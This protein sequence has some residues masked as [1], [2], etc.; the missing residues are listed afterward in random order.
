MSDVR[1]VDR[2]RDDVVGHAVVR[3]REQ[4]SGG[5]K[6]DRQEEV[7]QPLAPGEAPVRASSA[8]PHPGIAC[9]V[10]DYLVEERP[11]GVSEGRG[12]KDGCFFCIR[13]QTW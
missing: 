6:V 8:A 1:Q 10:L 7:D 11:R 12:G 3:S 5:Q 13:A 4:G 2:A 9:D